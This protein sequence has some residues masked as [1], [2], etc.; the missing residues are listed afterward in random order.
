M[1]GI[2]SL[3]VSYTS[4]TIFAIFA[5]VLGVN[6]AIPLGGIQLSLYRIVL[7]LSPF[8]LLLPAYNKLNRTKVEYGSE[9]LVFLLIWIIYSLFTGIW[10]QDYLSWFKSLFFLTAG[11]IFSVLI[12]S[13]INTVETFYKAIRIV[14]FLSIG[15]SFLGFYESLTGVYYFASQGGVEV[16]MEASLLQKAS[17]FREPITVFGNPNNYGLFLFFSTCFT[18]LLLIKG[19]GFIS[20]I[21]YALVLVLTLFLIVITLSRSAFIGILLFFIVLIFLS[22]YNGSRKLKK[23]ILL[24]LLV[25][26]ATAVYFVLQNFNLFEELLLLEFASEG[27]SDSIR[28]NLILNGFIFLTNTFFLGTG[29]GNI[30]HYMKLFSTYYV[31]EIV[32]VHNWWMEVLISSGVVIFILYLKL[33]GNT[34]LK[35][36]K[37]INPQNGKNVFWISCVFLS[38]L[39]GFVISSVG[40]SSLIGCEW[41]WPLIALTFKAP[42]IT[43]NQKLI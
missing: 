6:F 41:F 21:F 38:L 15:L 39:V 17:F 30:E 3:K 4:F 7:L 29:L 5:C 2:F 14:V 9:Y 37:G 27:T 25:A 40:P 31:G 23:R 24:I 35:L 16:N 10:V 8:F 11:Y 43:E 18:T 42:F 1:G 26:G 20:K 34:M 22:F 36:L 28:K 33:Y 13:N 12:F 32:N 19:K